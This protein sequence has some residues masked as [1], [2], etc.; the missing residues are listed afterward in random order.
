MSAQCTVR[1]ITSISCLSFITATGLNIYIYINKKKK[2]KKKL[3]LQVYLIS[4]QGMQCGKKWGF[5]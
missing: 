5:A 4:K 2:R 3:K 1:H